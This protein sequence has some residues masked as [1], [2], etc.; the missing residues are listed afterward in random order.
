[1]EALTGSGLEELDLSGNSIGKSTKRNE[2][3]E[4]FQN[5]FAENRDIM[6]V[7]LNWNNIRGTMGNSIILG[8][9]Q[10]E[11]LKKLE[12]TNNLLGINYE[13]AEAPANYL[14]ILLSQQ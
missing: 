11:K 1:M 12:M 3:G 6:K 13:S 8:L 14:S 7:K 10:A 9:A 5:F 2:C 4:A